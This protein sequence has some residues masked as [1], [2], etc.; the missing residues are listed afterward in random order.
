[1]LAVSELAL[2]NDEILGH[3][4]PKIHEMLRLARL[5]QLRLA[6]I[7]RSLGGHSSSKAGVVLVC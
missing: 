5:Y 7:G 6:S 2:G 1:M 3:H 4:F